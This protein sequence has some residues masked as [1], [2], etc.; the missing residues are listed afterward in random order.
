MVPYRGRYSLRIARLV[1]AA[2]CVVGYV[3]VSG[4]RLTWVIALLAAYLVYAVGSMFEVRFDSTFRTNVGLVVDTAFF[5]FWTFLAP[6]GWAGST[7]AGW[8]SALDLAYLLTATVLLQEVSRVA[9]VAL[10]VLID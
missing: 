5:G 7:P 4:W 2:A 9:L 6:G 8:L 10:V 1:L 3:R